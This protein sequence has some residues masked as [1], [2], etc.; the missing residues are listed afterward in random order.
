MSTGSKLEKVREVRLVPVAVVVALVA[1]GLVALVEKG[2]PGGAVALGPSPLNPLSYGTRVLYELVR[3]RYTTYVVTSPGEL[4]R[5]RAGRCVYALVSPERPVVEAEDVLSKLLSGCSE[6]AILV[7]DEGTGSNSLLRATGSSISVAGNRVGVLSGGTLSLHPNATIALGGRVYRVALDLASEVSGGRPVGYVEGTAVVVDVNS[8][9]PIRRGT[10]V[11]AAEEALGRVRVLVIG[12]GSVLL[13]QV[14]TSNRTEYREL[15]L[16][17]FDYLCG[18]IP[19][20]TVLLDAIHNPVVSP[21]EA[22]K[23]P[24]S[25]ADYV[26]VALALVATLIHPA[27][28]LPHLLRLLDTALGYVVRPPIGYATISVASLYLALALSRGYSPKRDAP[29]PEQVEEEL[30]VAADVRRAILSGAVRLGPRDFVNLYSIVDAVST[31][32]LGVGLPSAEFP[33]VLGRYLGAD[34]AREYWEMMNRYYRRATGA[35]RR[36]MVVCWRRVV[37][38]AIEASETVLNALGTSL[39]T[40][41]GAEYLLARGT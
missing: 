18:G 9:E 32:V 36:P 20:C 7:A 35:S 3:S 26:Y 16:G 22:L 28:W 21:L 33:Q 10:G 38:G 17:I 2:V 13:N 4:S 31:R 15:A 41:Y 39:E 27:T 8:T 37:L 6:V 24:L 25:P 30:Y 19:S 12:D 1:V 40:T 11:V 14:L 29:L 5:V 34:P 23:A